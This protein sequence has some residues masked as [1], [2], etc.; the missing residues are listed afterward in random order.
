MWV[1]MTD[2]RRHKVTEKKDGNTR[3]WGKR[4]VVKGEWKSV[5][6]GNY[7]KPF[8]IF[9]S[10]HSNSYL[11]T[12]LI[13]FSL[14]LSS[15]SI[16]H[17]IIPLSFPSFT[18]FHSPS[19]LSFHCCF[20]TVCKSSNQ[21]WCRPHHDWGQRPSVDKLG[22]GVPDWEDGLGEGKWLV[23]EVLGDSRRQVSSRRD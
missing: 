4:Q 3:E 16:Y 14:C 6:R 8:I 19:L 11:F 1:M 18:Y 12:S 7:I 13:S 15:S 21:A 5:C 22:W 20:S 10:G 2:E 9:Q 17:F 23:L